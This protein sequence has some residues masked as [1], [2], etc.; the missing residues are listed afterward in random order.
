[1]RQRTRLTTLA[2]S[3]VIA[4]SLSSASGATVRPIVPEM[5]PIPS[6]AFAMGSPAKEY[7]GYDDE[8]PR[9]AVRVSAF[10]MGKYEVTQS[11]WVA[12]MGWNPSVF[13][14]DGLPVDSVS[15]YAAI[16]YCNR[17]SIREGFA[18]C[19]RIDGEADP[20]LWGEIPERWDRAWSEVECDFGANGFRL[21]TEAEWEY[22]CRA[23]TSTPNPW[24]KTLSAAQANFDGS[25]PYGEAEYLESAGMT[26]EV[27]S[28]AP[29]AWGLYD[30]LGNLWEWAWDWV[31]EEY[32]G[33]SP[34][35]DPTGPAR[36]ETKVC[37]GGAWKSSGTGARSAHRGVTDEPWKASDDVGFRV[38]RRP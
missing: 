2:A 29:N 7:G 6:G 20:D 18:P 26:V 35:Q 12:V 34:L 11:Q 15:W 22:A 38:V 1:M 23:G 19:Y 37:R 31:D 32:Y 8:R 3:I 9:H 36:G 21:P 28:Y 16:A 14:G 10:H 30:M 33:Y 25:E 13:A 24:G 5:V 27:G 4:V 17:L